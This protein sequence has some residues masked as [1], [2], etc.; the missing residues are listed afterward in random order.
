M[1]FARHMLML[2]HV[3]RIRFL[4]LSVVVFLEMRWQ[5]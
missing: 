3:W 2:Q 5:V 4:R 1:Q